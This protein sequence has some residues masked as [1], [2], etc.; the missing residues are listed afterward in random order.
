LLARKIA[1]GSAGRCFGFARLSA[2]SIYA[3]ALLLVLL[4]VLGVLFW[5]ALSVRSRKRRLGIMAALIGG[6]CPEQPFADAQALIEAA[7]G[8]PQKQGWPRLSW[9]T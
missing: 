5:P 9:P 1:L 6:D 3:A 4:G 7:R 8:E 2:L